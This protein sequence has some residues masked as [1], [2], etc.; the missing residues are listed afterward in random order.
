[1]D[2]QEESIRVLVSQGGSGSRR[3]IM[4]GIRTADPTAGPE[5]SRVSG[6]NQGVPPP[7]GSKSNWMMMNNLG[8]FSSL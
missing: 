4:L 7:V 6:T 8:F 1:M 5:P 3:D 2:P